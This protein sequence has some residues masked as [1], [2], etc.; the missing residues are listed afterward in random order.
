MSTYQIVFTCIFVVMSVL[1]FMVMGIDKSKAKKGQR[2]IKEAVLFAFAIL[3]GAVGSM[4]IY[5]ATRPSIGILRCSFRFL[6]SSISRFTRW[7]CISF[8]KDNTISCV[9]SHNFV[10]KNT[11]RI[12]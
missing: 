6:R 2:R 5:S 10:P 4:L 3:G 8:D 1:G 12:I 7:V 11:N 9:L